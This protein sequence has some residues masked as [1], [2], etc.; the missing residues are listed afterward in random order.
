MT[1]NVMEIKIPE[2]YMKVFREEIEEFVVDIMIEGTIGGIELHV[3]DI[4]RHRDEII[5]E[6]DTILHDTVETINMQ[7]DSGEEELEF[8]DPI[9]DAMD[10]W[11]R[12]VLFTDV[13]YRNPN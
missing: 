1:E 13:P 2:E 3:V 8:D 7:D 6:L 11:I 10:T 4:I 12:A 5:D 9:V